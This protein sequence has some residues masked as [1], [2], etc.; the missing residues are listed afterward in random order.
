VAEDSGRL[1]GFALATEPASGAQTDPPDAAVL[2]LLAVSPHAQGDGLGRSLLRATVDGLATRGYRQ[3]VL[4]VLADNL[5][6]VRLYESEGWRRRGDRFAHPLL[7]RMSET[8]V[9][10]L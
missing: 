7:Q 8:Y 9:T 3:A 5:A 4:H 2:G 1:V 10:D 6:A